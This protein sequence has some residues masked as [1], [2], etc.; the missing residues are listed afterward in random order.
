MLVNSDAVTSTDIYA[1]YQALNAMGE[2]VYFMAKVIS[3]AALF[4]FGNPPHILRKFYHKSAFFSFGK[5]MRNSFAR[6]GTRTTFYFTELF[7]EREI[8][9]K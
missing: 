7:Q 5:A 2:N 3:T 1:C 4:V 6:S 8:L 9:I